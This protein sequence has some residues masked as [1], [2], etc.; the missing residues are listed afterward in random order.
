MK[1]TSC[2]LLLFAAWCIGITV[3]FAE[4]YTSAQNNTYF[5]EIKNKYNWHNS[6]TQCKLKNLTL[7]SI[8][9]AEKTQ[10]INELINEHFKETEKPLLYIGANDLA[11]EGRF[12]WTSNAHEFNYT[13]WAESEPN[14][15]KNH[16]NCVH[17]GLYND[18]TWNDVD[19]S[20]KFGYICEKKEEQK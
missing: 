17:I 19:C 3:V 15:Y 12:R 10:E 18:G 13:N 9:S 6:E 2:F 7:L 16:E 4:Y 20:T 8:E 5:I 1:S 11:E 14:N